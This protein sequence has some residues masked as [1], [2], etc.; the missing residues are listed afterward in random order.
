MEALIRKLEKA[1]G[2]DRELDALIAAALPLLP[3]DAPAWLV[4]WKGG[5]AADGRQVFA[6]H[7]DGRRGV[8]WSAPPLTGSL[9]AALTLVK[10]GYAVEIAICPEMKSTVARVYRGA[11]RENSAG[12]PTGY[13][14]NRDLAVCIASLRARESRG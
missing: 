8:N 7:S 10:P 14:A 11:I 4:N 6:M 5:F 12:E 3:P 2:P 1:E 9:D 13:S